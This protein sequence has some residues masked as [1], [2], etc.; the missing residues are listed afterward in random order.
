MDF[1]AAPATGKPARPSVSCNL[2][3]VSLAWVSDCLGLIPDQSA[4]HPAL[5]RSPL[6]HQ[7]RYQSPSVVGPAYRYGAEHTERI[8]RSPNMHMSVRC[9]QSCV[10]RCRLDAACVTTG[11][12]T[13]S[14]HKARQGDRSDPPMMIAN[15]KGL[16]VTLDT[17]FLPSRPGQRVVTSALDPAGSSPTRSGQFFGEAR[18][19]LEPRGPWGSCPAVLVLRRR[20]KLPKEK[21]PAV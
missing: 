8:S 18:R 13:L 2:E 16:F 1:L 14:T 12:Q 11:P 20:K 19:E 17:A 7:R 9:M 3:P 4:L 10:L 21:E 5:V 15:T 6:R